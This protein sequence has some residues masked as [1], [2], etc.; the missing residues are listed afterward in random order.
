M[1]NKTAFRQAILA[2]LESIVGRACYNGKIQNWGPGGV[3][4]GEGRNFRYPITYL[5]NESS[6]FPAQASLK[7][8]SMDVMMTGHYRFGANKLYIM[9]ALDKVLHH[10]EREHGL[11]IGPAQ[12]DKVTC[13]YC[14]RKVANVI[15]HVSQ[16]HPVQWAEYSKKPE[17]AEYV[18]GRHRCAQCGAILN[19]ADGHQDRCPGKLT[20]GE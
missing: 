17:V 6:K 3:W 4:L 10:L 5:D 16:S 1:S 11:K 12:R 13:P 7:P 18:K 20:T 2:E 15:A 8:M 14:A 9:R 19:K